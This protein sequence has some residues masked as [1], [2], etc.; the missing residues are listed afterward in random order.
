MTESIQQAL[1]THLDPALAREAI[2]LLGQVPPGFH[3]TDGD[4]RLDPLGGQ[5][6]HEEHLLQDLPVGLA[7]HDH[8]QNRIELVGHLG[9][10]LERVSGDWSELSRLSSMSQSTRWLITA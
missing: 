5:P 4:C 2:D 3:E 7:C 8:V 1:H 9:S 10:G 6:G